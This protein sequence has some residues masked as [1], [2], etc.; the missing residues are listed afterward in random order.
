MPP[1]ITVCTLLLKLPP[2][3]TAYVESPFARGRALELPA[4]LNKEHKAAGD[5]VLHLDHMFQKVASV[6]TPH[7]AAVEAAGLP[8]YLAALVALTALA[9]LHF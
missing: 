2:G 3:E 8:A 4:S 6:V 9:T 1:W 7:M 5:G